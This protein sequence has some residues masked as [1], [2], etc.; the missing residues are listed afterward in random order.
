M[1]RLKSIVDTVNSEEHRALTFCLH[2]VHIR[3]SAMR[4][5]QITSLHAVGA[6]LHVQ[7]MVYA[8]WKGNL[9]NFFDH[10]DTTFV[11]PIARPV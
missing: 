8:F 5:K 3:C 9:E 10:S 11:R 2:D 6:L 7:G 4:Q 1:S